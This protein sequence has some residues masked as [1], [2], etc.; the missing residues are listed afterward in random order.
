M[1]FNRQK[2]VAKQLEIGKQRA[3]R[4]KQ[5]E[6]AKRLINFAVLAGISLIK[7][8]PKNFEFNHLTMNDFIYNNDFI[9]AVGMFLI[10]V[11]T[12]LEKPINVK[13]IEAIPNNVN[14]FAAEY[15]PKT[16]TYNNESLQIS[17]LPQ[18]L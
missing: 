15:L 18:A 4:I 16:Q 6:R 14:F 12:P 5:K 8:K 11:L 10:E 13:K 2:R 9:A 17:P 7:D 3:L 1:K